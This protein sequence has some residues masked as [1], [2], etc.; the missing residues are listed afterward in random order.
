MA[1]KQV[2]E[3]KEDAALES[4]SELHSILAIWTVQ[5]LGIQST[6]IGKKPSNK[7]ARDWLWTL[8]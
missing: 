5:R 3:W 2:V 8:R 7:I 4:H 1:L 6:K